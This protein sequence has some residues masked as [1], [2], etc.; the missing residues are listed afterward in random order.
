MKNTAR[1]INLEGELGEKFG[2]VWHLNVKSPAEA[3]RA[4]DAQRKGFRKYFLDT[5]EKGIGYEVIVGDQGLQ[6][7][8][9]L[10]YPAP[11]RDD[12]TFV[13]VPQGGKS[14]A[15]GMIMLGAAIF[16]TAGAAAGWG[17]VIAPAGTVSGTAGG[18]FAAL[19]GSSAVASL[20][21]PQTMSLAAAY[22]GASGFTGFAMSMG[23][24]MMLGGVAQLLAPTIESSAGNEE[25][26][27]LFDG[28]VNSVKQGT[29][30]PILY[31]RLT[32]GGA[33]ISASI[34]SNQET[35]RVRGKKRQMV[36][37]VGG[38]PY[39][40]GG[41]IFG[42]P[43]GGI[44]QPGCF[45]EGTMVEMADGT[46]KE[47]TSI[48]LG[49]HT[50]GGIVYSTMQFLPQTI[51]DYKGVKVS[52][53]H[54]VYE[55]GQF[56]EVEDSKHG[57][58]TDQVEPVHTLVTSD[59]TIY[60]KGIKFGDYSSVDEIEWQPYYEIIKDKINKRLAKEQI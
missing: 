17:S 10:L 48:K 55:E 57:I 50:R 47:I 54:Y 53:T 51:Y 41:T 37:G 28:A 29:P 7:E 15:M 38:G 33:T 19:G 18:G 56:I 22:S 43:Q 24:A 49:D 32:V 42:N 11:M 3:V 16:L 9:G 44:N 1:K 13:P 39:F 20:A 46:E 2:K 40:G 12:Y 5:G 60:S 52:G 31:G 25:Q 21:G 30:I 14:R 27:Y 34:K 58:L 8:E 36:Y 4:I 45:I 23:G 35:G 6:Q 26:S 59:H